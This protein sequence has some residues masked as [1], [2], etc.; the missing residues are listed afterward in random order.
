[1]VLLSTHNIC[2]GWEIK[3][4]KFSYTFLS[5]GLLSRYL[6]SPLNILWLVWDNIVDLWEGYGCDWHMTLSEFKWCHCYVKVMWCCCIA[7]QCIQELLWAFFKKNNNLVFNE[8]QEKKSLLVWKWDKK[9]RPL[10][11]LYVIFPQ[12]SWY[13]TMILRTD[14]SI[15]S[16]LLR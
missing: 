13:Q 6:A 3:K 11:S 2:F 7:S 8:E 16:S 1:M 5:G 9:I 12:A 4:K 10:G 15:L 14:F